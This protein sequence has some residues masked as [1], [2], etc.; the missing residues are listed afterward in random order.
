MIN[1][2][3]VSFN[4][5]ALNVGANTTLKAPHTC[6][7]NHIQSSESQVNLCM[8]EVIVLPKMVDLY[9]DRI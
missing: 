2:Q 5:L 3:P 1:G 9:F 7:D 4:S 6:K 8:Y